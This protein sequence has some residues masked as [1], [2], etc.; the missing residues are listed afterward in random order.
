M[1]VMVKQVWATSENACSN[2][3]AH[4]IHF[5]SLN[6][7]MEMEVYIKKIYYMIHVS[8]CTWFN[9]SILQCNLTFYVY[10]RHKMR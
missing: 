8:C 1:F 6:E 10:I 4:L 5:D 3:G 2:V 7:L 9:L